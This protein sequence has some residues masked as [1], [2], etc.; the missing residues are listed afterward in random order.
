LHLVTL[1][2][3]LVDGALDLGCG[4]IYGLNFY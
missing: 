1:P 3:Q 4:R 2:I